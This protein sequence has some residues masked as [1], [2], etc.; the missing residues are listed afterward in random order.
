MCHST[1]LWSPVTVTP[2]KSIEVITNEPG[3]PG[4]LL[5]D[6]EI[7]TPNADDPL[8]SLYVATI[9]LVEVRMAEMVGDTPFTRVVFPDCASGNK[10][11]TV[12]PDSE[13]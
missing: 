3:W 1:E 11:V 10:Y 9:R 13:K 4:V 7:S 5:L 12:Q 6:A 8:V 2:D